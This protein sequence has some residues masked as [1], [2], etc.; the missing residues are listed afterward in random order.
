MALKLNLKKYKIPGCLI[1]LICLVIHYREGF[2]SREQTLCGE[3][4]ILTSVFGLFIAFPGGGGVLPYVAY[5]AIR[6]RAAGQGMVFGLC[7]EQGI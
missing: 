1:T 3:D 6:G 4:C 7:P 5:H 2:Y